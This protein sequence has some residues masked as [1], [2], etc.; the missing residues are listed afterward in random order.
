MQA[1]IA[2]DGIVEEFA[3]EFRVRWH[4]LPNKGLF[5]GLLTAWMLLFQF[6]GVSTLGYVPSA[7]LPGWMLGVYLNGFTQDEVHGVLV[8]FIVLGLFWWKRKTLLA[9]PARLWWPGL[10]GVAFAL[11][12]H[13]AG[14]M[15]Q[16]PRVSIVAMFTGIYFL[17]GL[18]WGPRWMLNSFFPFVLLVFCI[19]LSTLAFFNNHITFPLRILTGQIVAFIAHLGLAPDLVRQGTQLS[20]AQGTFRYDIA[21]ACSGIRGLTAL[22]LMTITYGMI[23]FREPWKRAVMIVSAVPLAVLN[24]V[25]RLTFTVLVAEVGGHE[26][27]AAVEQKT[28][29]VTFI[30][31]AIPLVL[32]LGRL[33]GDHWG[34]PAEPERAES[35]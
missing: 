32:L 1:D 14:Y 8:P 19:P 33:L 17:I 22:A 21:P 29:F 27:G 15:V 26:A 4:E 25:I 5:F 7:S 35:P 6:L 23:V 11:M 9:I 3:S 10:L 13:I 12:L 28:G 20:D 18:A 24:N 16:Q 34:R 2:R 30:L 31:I